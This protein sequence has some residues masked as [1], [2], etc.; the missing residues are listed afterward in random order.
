M[1]YHLGVEEHLFKHM[2]DL[3]GLDVRETE[4]LLEKWFNKHY[5]DDLVISAFQIIE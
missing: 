1:D 4:K 5:P 2:M 3:F